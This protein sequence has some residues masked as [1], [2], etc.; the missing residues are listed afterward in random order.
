MQP[1]KPRGGILVR[2]AGVYPAFTGRLNLHAA[3]A[4]DGNAADRRRTMPAL[5][6]QR[7]WSGATGNCGV[8]PGH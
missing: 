6:E 4:S 3:T 1:S 8:R 5:S 2:L 7:S